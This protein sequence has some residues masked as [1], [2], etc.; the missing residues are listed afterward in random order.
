[1]KKI[2]KITTLLTGLLFL[3]IGVYAAD[4][5]PSID[6]EMATNDKDAD[7]APGPIIVIGDSVEWTY[8]V[9]NT[10]NVVLTGIGV[11]DTDK[12]GK[13]TLITCLYSV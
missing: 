1:M 8:K 10:G 9:T 13:I 6:I 5:K 4:P 2:V 12:N 11:I 3:A 7:Y